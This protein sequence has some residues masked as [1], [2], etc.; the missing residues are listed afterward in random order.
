MTVGKAKILDVL[1]IPPLVQIQA[2][3]LGP[4]ATALPAPLDLSERPRHFFPVVDFVHDGVMRPEARR[5]LPA[6]EA[7]RGPLT[8]QPRM[9]V[10]GRLPASPVGHGNGNALVQPERLRCCQGEAGR[11]GRY[12]LQCRD[13]GRFELAAG[14]R[15]EQC[16]VRLQFVEMSG[17]VLRSEA[18]QGFVM[19]GVREQG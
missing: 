11:C 2:Q 19:M 16:Q 3:S 4:A 17:E 9:H 12:R 1:P 18:R 6:Q 7:R 15:V 14:Q 13:N 8:L 5:V 10:F